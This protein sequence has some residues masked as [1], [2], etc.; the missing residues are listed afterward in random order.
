[1]SEGNRAG[2]GLNDREERFSCWNSR[3]GAPLLLL[4]LKLFS[5][6]EVSFSFSGGLVA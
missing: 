4:M 1:M 5:N 3:F 6:P 2:F